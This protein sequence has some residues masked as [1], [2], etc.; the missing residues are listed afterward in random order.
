MQEL[1][2]SGSY[3]SASSKLKGIT[4]VM[5]YRDDMVQPFATM[6]EPSKTFAEYV[7][8]HNLEDFSTRCLQWRAHH[9]RIAERKK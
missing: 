1:S 7:L 8:E 5:H 2:Q 6:I 4:C 3:T 9:M